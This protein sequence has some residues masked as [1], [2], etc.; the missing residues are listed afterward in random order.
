MSEDWLVIKLDFA[1]S[2]CVFQRLVSSKH[3]WT[4]LVVCVI[5]ACNFSSACLFANHDIYFTVR[6]G[7]DIIENGFVTYYDHLSVHSDLPF[8][9][10]RIFV[11]LSSYFIDSLFGEIGLFIASVLLNS[12]VWFALYKVICDRD[13]SDDKLYSKLF[14]LILFADLYFFGGFKATIFTTFVLL[15]IWHM[16][17]K[18]IH[19]ELKSDM[20]YYISCFVA[21]CFEMWIQS[22]TW[23]LCF[24]VL[25]PYLFDFNFLHFGIFKFFDC[26]Y[27]KWRIWLAFVFMFLGGSLNPY[28]INVFDYVYRCMTVTF[29]CDYVSLF[30]GEMHSDLLG[31][32]NIILYVLTFSNICLMWIYNKFPL[33]AVYFTFGSFIMSLLAF[34][35]VYTAIVFSAFAF[36]IILRDG[37]VY[38]D[39][40][41]VVSCFDVKRVTIA[42]CSLLFV[43]FVFMGCYG[44]AYSSGEGS[45]D[46]TNNK[47]MGV[48]RSLFDNNDA[49]KARVF[50]SLDAGSYV[51]YKGGTSYIDDRAEFFDDDFYGYHTDLFEEYLLLYRDGVYKDLSY[52]TD[53][54]SF[55]CKFQDDYM[56]DYYILP[57]HT[58]A[59]SQIIDALY[60]SANVLYED[61]YV[62][63]AS[64]NHDVVTI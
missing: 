5:V 15:F 12:V 53:G 22:S 1:K 9:N 27:S 3:F 39:R 23:F 56:M 42:Y 43:S 52:S 28:G 38:N 55:L 24:V 60:D 46:F 25:M 14:I 8:T 17:E 7:A 45:S 18:F 37:S 40:D 4:V 33:R 29:R 30:I 51:L 49:K 2:C 20:I 26:K 58:L 59:Y 35:L 44:V 41:S 63:V 21:G 57:L 48:I 11:C 32:P 10:Q 62:I 47:L 64:Y 36:A 13:T 54:A 31:I 6:Q 19:G 34:R 16:T 61:D 50:T